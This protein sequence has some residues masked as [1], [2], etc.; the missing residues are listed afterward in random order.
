MI[1][2]RKMKRPKTSR[3][4]KMRRE[5]SGLTMG[6]LGAIYKR[7]TTTAVGRQRQQIA[8][9]LHDKIMRENLGLWDVEERLRVSSEQRQFRY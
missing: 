9:N 8:K 4:F 7:P 1:R 2:A 3:A 6:Q 5:M